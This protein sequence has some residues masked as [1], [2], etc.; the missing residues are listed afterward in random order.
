MLTGRSDIEDKVSGF[1]LGADDYM[2]KPFHGRELSARVEAILRRPSQLI[3]NSLVVGDYAF[4][5]QNGSIKCSGRNV[6]LV[7]RE[8]ALVEFLMKYPGQ[9]FS[10]DTLLN[11]IW[12][13]D[14]E[15]TKLAIFT[16]VKR[17][18]QKLAVENAEHI[19]RNERGRG[20]SFSPEAPAE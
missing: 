11:R 5:R 2:T 6:Q 1:D 4:D 19:I 10:V 16:C 14:S 7:P 12:P 9:F 20:Y 17:L 8:A 18:R 3:Q 15:A 13:N